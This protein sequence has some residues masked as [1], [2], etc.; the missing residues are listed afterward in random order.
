ML[1]IN[2]VWPPVDQ[3]FQQNIVNQ[4]LLGKA[5]QARQSGQLVFAIRQL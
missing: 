5:R 4:A 1:H 2:T 3:T